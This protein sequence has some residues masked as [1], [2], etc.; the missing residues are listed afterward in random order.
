MP[1]A[2]L[3]LQHHRPPRGRHRH[4]AAEL[5]GIADP[6]L[7]ADQQRAAGQLFAIPARLRARRHPCRAG[8]ESPLV[9][10]PSGI[11][12]AGQQQGDPQVEVQHRIVG[13][14]AQR[15]AIAL[16]GFHRPPQ[17]LQHAR[18][19]AL[20]LRIAWR[21][22]HRLT[23][24]HGGLLQPVRLAQHQTHVVVQVRQVGLVP[25]RVAIG[26]QRLLRP[27]EIAQHMPH[28]LSASAELRL[29]PQRRLAGRQRGV[30]LAQ[31]QQ[32]GRAIDVEHRG[33]R[34]D[35]D[36]L[37]DAGHRRL[38]L[39]ALR[40]DHAQ[41]VQAVGMPGRRGE[42]LA[43]HLLG[44]GQPAGAMQPD[45]ALEIR[46]DCVL[47]FAHDR[48]PVSTA[49]ARRTMDRRLLAWAYASRRPGAKLPR[50]W[51]FTDARRLPDPRPSVARLPR[52]LAGV[53][54]RH[55]G[56]PGRAA[57]GRD[58]AR[59]CRARRLALVVAG[60]ARLAAALG[61][62]VHLRA[63]RWPGVLRR[64]RRLITSSAHGRADLLRAHRAGAGLAFL[65]P[66]FPTLSHPGRRRPRTGPLD[67]PG[68]RRAPARRGT[69]RRRRRRRPAPAAPHL[70]GRGSDRRPGLTAM[71]LFD[72]SVSRLP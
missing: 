45:P 68:S 66:A 64:R 17:F 1:Q 53:V 20:R 58:L 63:G 6:L 51:L 13:M 43:I 50:L 72:H 28:H 31:R 9:F 57:L 44:L 2:R 36:R 41:H 71:C 65:S 49:A 39:A 67:A 25:Q 69:R 23:K 38:R 21:A 24:C 29:Q 62:G 46:L 15:G 30:Q 40:G 19:V 16:L 7:G 37:V 47:P 61:A 52:G 10:L 59:I 14:Q 8:A 33:R 27:S 34:L 18:Q 48:R 55:D 3:H 54:L 35:R 32:R 4:V 56:E 60:D 26:G 70:P 5:D 22:L 11:E 12:P 42:H